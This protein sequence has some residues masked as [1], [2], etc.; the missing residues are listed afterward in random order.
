MSKLILMMGAPGSGKS[1]WIKDNAAAGDI[2]VSRDQI[3]FAMVAEDEEYFSKEN[4]VFEVFAKTIRE[5][6]NAGCCVWA[7]ATHLTPKSRLKFLNAVTAG[8]TELPHLEIVYIAKDLETCLE[9]NENRRNT[10][11]FVPCGVVRRMWECIEEPC[12]KEGK[13]YYD[14]ITTVKNHAVINEIRRD[15]V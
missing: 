11:A 14:K 3:R 1:T 8:M 13:F 5:Y 6:L 7:D 12:F 15:N 10:R 2:V 9:Q 4:E